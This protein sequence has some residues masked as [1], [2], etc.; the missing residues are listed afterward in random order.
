MLQLENALNDFTGASRLLH[1]HCA[2]ILRNNGL[3][4]SEVADAL[5]SE[6]RTRRRD[7]H[8]K[9]LTQRIH[10]ATDLLDIR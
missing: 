8:I 1:L 4:F 9:F 10:I 5:E 6:V 3:L 7:L 2:V